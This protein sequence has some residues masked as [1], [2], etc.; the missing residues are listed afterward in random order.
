MG[1]A[2]II[3]VKRQY[4]RHPSSF[5]VKLQNRKRALF[6]NIP[7]RSSRTGWFRWASCSI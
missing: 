7:L 1:I 5:F 2:K 3:M 6:K 4:I